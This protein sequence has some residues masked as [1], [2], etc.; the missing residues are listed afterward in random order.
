VQNIEICGDSLPNSICVSCIFAE[1]TN[2]QGCFIRLFEGHHS[3]VSSTVGINI[4][5]ERDTLNATGC[6][7]ELERAMYRV[8]VYDI[9]ADGTVDWDNEALSIIASVNLTS[10]LNSTGKHMSTSCLEQTEQK[11]VGLSSFI[12]CVCFVF[13]AL[14]LECCY[15]E[16]QL[17]T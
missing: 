2:T 12:T 4:K 6:I 11:D 7:D 10:S 3:A 14:Y 9:E 13:M 15:A 1:G 17:P 16:L 5:R 8:V